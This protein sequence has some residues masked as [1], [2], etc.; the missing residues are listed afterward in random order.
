MK[1]LLKRILFATVALAT[2]SVGSYAN[3]ID[4]NGAIPDEHLVTVSDVND[5]EISIVVVGNSILAHGKSESIGWY[6]EGWGMAASAADKDYFTILSNKV[7][8]SGFTNVKW[9]KIGFATFERLIDTRMDYDYQREIDQFLAPTVQRVI[10]DVV[11]FQI[12]ENV[13]S[14]HTK[15]SYA[16]ALVKM[17]EYCEKINPEVDII[18]CKPFWGGNSKVPG[19]EIAA[20]KTGH[21]YADLS[22]F[23]NEENMAIGLFE[24]TGVARHPGDAGM[25]NIADEIYSQLSIILNKKYVNKEQVEVKLDGKYMTFDVPAQIINGRT[26]VPVRAISDAFDAEVGWDAATQTVSIK[27]D[28]ADIT[29]V[30]GESF[31]TKNGQKIAL[32]VPAQSV[33]W[34]T[35]VPIRAI[36]EVLDCDVDWDADNWTAIITKKVVEVKKALPKEILN[37]DCGNLR[38]YQ[39]FSSNANLTVVEDDNSDNKYINVVSNQGASKTWTYIWA[40]MD[41]IPG[42]TYLIDFEVKLIDKD[43][44]GNSVQDATVGACLHYSSKDNGTG[45]K[46]VNLSDGWKK[47][48]FEAKVPDNTIPNPDDD[49]FGVYIN[50][51]NDIGA[52]F[53]IDNINV[54]LKS[55]SVSDNSEEKQEA[56]NNGALEI[57]NAKGDVFIAGNGFAVKGLDKAELSADNRVVTLKKSDSGITVSHGGY[58]TDGK[59]WGG[60]AAKVPQKLDGMKVT[61][62]L[63]KVPVVEENHDC[64]VSVSFLNKP[65]LFQVGNIPNNK[66]FINLIR[67]SKNTF[68]IYEGMTRWTGASTLISETNMYSLKSGDVISVSAKLVD[69]KYEFTYENGKNKATYRYDSD[70][71]TKLFKDG[72]AHLVISASSNKS[73]KDAFV[74]TITEYTYNK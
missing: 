1:N 34:R 30:L 14:S 26:M 36:S 63:D 58:Y 67:F 52:S 13:S 51:V 6:G 59:N 73:D 7:A 12:G 64:W 55:G 69:G 10:P 17:A 61:I 40:N 43:G 42:E 25:K 24:H 38:K 15:D 9:S 35:L 27:T 60:I 62:K 41:F 70:E 16:H 11:I 46:A 19:V 37:D 49:R 47:L 57:A 5:T 32:D 2:L 72:K 8:D 44:A 31:F 20:K 50:P 56:N 22:Q 45:V 23:N 28:T 39:Y 54:R 53:S 33:N 4:K 71:F 3:D 68:E 29:I 74:Y 18:F 48:S 66:G 65:E 21:T